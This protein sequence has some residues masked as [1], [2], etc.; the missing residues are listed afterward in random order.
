MAFLMA[1]FVP[2]VEF[3]MKYL[4]FF[5]GAV[6]LYFILSVLFHHSRALIG[7]IYGIVAILTLMSNMGGAYDALQGLFTQIGDAS[8]KAAQSYQEYVSENIYNDDS[9][10]WYEKLEKTIKAGVV[11]ASDNDNTAQ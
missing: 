3:V 8:G 1:V 9:L 7:L 5:V 4:A 11:G 6:L 2:I 10:T